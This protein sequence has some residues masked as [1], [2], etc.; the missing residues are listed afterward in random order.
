MGESK[1]DLKIVGLV[2]TVSITVALSLYKY[3]I[4]KWTPEG[5]YQVYL[6]QIQYTAAAPNRYRILVPHIVKAI[7]SFLP[8]SYSHIDRFL[9]SYLFTYIASVTLGLT[10]LYAY[11]RLWF[12]RSLSLLGVLVTGISML[13]AFGDGFFQPWSLLEIGIF[14]LCLLA[15]YYQRLGLLFILVI[16]ATLNRETGILVG[17]TYLLTQSTWN[18]FQFRVP[19]KVVMWTCCYLLVGGLVLIG[20]RLWLGTAEQLT[21]LQVLAVNLDPLNLIAGAGNLILFLGVFWW[22]IGKGYH[23]SPPFVKKTWRIVPLYVLVVAVFGIWKEVRLL[24]LLY[25]ILMPTGISLLRE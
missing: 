5:A 8:E 7:G 21:L 4:V 25:P 6:S 24:T 10:T 3:A 20:L 2:V 15:I 17:V 22:F 12:S 19:N 16:I 14:T 11:L 13:V 9:A 23:L 18:K 1:R